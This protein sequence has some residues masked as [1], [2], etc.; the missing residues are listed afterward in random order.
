MFTA[1]CSLSPNVEE[2]LDKVAEWTGFALYI[3]RYSKEHHVWTIEKPAILVN[4]KQCRYYITLALIERNGKKYVDR[5]SSKSGC[6][7]MLTPPNEN[8]VKGI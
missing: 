4:N 5:I 7:C 3:F 2:A 8:C 1:T 6:N